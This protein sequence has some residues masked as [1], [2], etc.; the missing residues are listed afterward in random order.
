MKFCIAG[1][2]HRLQELCKHQL[3]LAEHLAYVL[4]NSDGILPQVLST[5]PNSVLLGDHV[6]IREQMV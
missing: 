6:V 1:V 2:N 4:N 5:L 3:C